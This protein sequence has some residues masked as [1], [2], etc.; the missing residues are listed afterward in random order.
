MECS[1]F[2]IF[3]LLYILNSP[4]NAKSAQTSFWRCGNYIKFFEQNIRTKDNKKIEFLNLDKDENISINGQTEEFKF[5]PNSICTEVIFSREDAYFEDPFT[6]RIFLPPNKKYKILKNGILQDKNIFEVTSSTDFEIEEID[7]GKVLKSYLK[8]FIKSSRPISKMSLY[9][10]PKQKETLF[11]THNDSA[12]SVENVFYNDKRIDSETIGPRGNTSKLYSKKPLSIQLSRKYKFHEFEASHILILSY[13]MDLGTYKAF[14]A[15]KL[16]NKLNLFPFKFELIELYANSLSKGIYLLF[17]LNKDFFLSEKKSHFVIRQSLAKNEIVYKEPQVKHKQIQL[18]FS[19]IHL[20]LSSPM[21]PTKYDQLNDLIN[22]ES[23]FKAIAF[24][25]FFKNPDYYD[26]IFIS[27]KVK[28]DGNLY[29]DRVLLWDVDDYSPVNVNLN[30]NSDGLAIDVFN[31]TSQPSGGF[32]HRLVK[33]NFFYSKYKAV[34]IDFLKNQLTIELIQKQYL[35]TKS[36]FKKL[37]VRQDLRFYH[38]KNEY[39]K[40][41]NYSLDYV[42]KTIESEGQYYVQQYNKKLSKL[43]N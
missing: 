18:I 33:D 37:W 29:F 39:Y 1:L 35:D 14:N 42:L 20:L 3:S 36:T 30:K 2:I 13:P 5:L 28:N 4:L 16:L 7:S 12:L 21:S 40:S 17:E 31:L 11:E 27:G 6:L 23:Y 43:S 26:E 32:E 10:E 15:F 38:L 41:T 24:Q 34:Y 22:V 9:L 25:D 8:S 19:K